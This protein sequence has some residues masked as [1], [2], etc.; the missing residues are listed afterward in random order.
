[1][2]TEYKDHPWIRAAIPIGHFVVE[3]G[4]FTTNILAK[5]GVI[6]LPPETLQRLQT[7]FFIDFPIL[8]V[9]FMNFMLNK[10]LTDT[11]NKQ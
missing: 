5:S 3:A 2:T 10:S 7:L 9:A 8:S 4:L 6:Y 11:T 1:M